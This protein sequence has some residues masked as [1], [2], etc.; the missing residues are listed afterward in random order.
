MRRWKT[1]LDRAFA[2]LP[3]HR[4]RVCGSA[5]DLIYRPGVTAGCCMLTLK[6]HGAIMSDQLAADALA[7]VGFAKVATTNWEAA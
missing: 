4:C 7:Q 2:A 6:A 3:K 1:P 5:L